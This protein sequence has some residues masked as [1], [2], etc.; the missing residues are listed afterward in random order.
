MGERLKNTLASV[1]FG[2]VVAQ[3]GLTGITGSPDL[4][5]EVYSTSAMFEP[6]NAGSDDIP[7]VGISTTGDYG[8]PPGMAVGSQAPI[9]HDVEAG[10]SSLDTSVRRLPG[11]T[12]QMAH[13]V[14]Q[15]GI[16]ALVYEDPE[17]KQA[18]REIG[19]GIG[20]G[21]RHLAVALGKDLVASAKQSGITR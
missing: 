10:I 5:D 4:D 2:V 11:Y 9:V 14:D 12:A 8:P 13:R 21:F 19:A 6:G 20:T 1:I 16:R 17:L 18:G 7:P 15:H 3:Y